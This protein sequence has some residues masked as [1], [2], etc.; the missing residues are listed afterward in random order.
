MPIMH[1][2]PYQLVFDFMWLSPYHGVVK[3]HQSH[4][5]MGCMLMKGGLGHDP[6]NICGNMWVSLSEFGAPPHQKVGMFGIGLQI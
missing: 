6:Q 1:M 3:P 5:W 2:I 4:F